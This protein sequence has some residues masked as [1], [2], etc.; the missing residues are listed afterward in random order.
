[1]DRD[2][3]IKRWSWKESFIACDVPIHGNVEIDKGDLIF[4]DNANGLRTRGSSTRD[5]YGY[6]FSK[7]SGSTLSLSSNRTLAK[8]HFLGVAATYSEP[9]VTENIGVYITGL[10]RF[11]LKNS[12]LLKLGYYIVP[13]GS[14]V[15]L[16]NQKVAISNSTTNKIGV[17]GK[18]GT[19]QAE[20]E[21]SIQSRVFGIETDLP[22]NP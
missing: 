3:R 10:F 4:L 1:M 16:Y 12:R 7:V 5:W 9:G 14:G 19:F 22:N 18:Y 11:N 15:T 2:R 8:D 13:A 21:M 20:V 6:P 17:V